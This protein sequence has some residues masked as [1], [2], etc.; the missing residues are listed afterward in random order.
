VRVARQVRA[1]L[2]AGFRVDVVALRGQGEPARETIDGA[3]VLRLPI[4][5]RRGAGMLR[6]VLEYTGFVLL[7]SIVVAS[8]MPRRRYDVVQVHNPPDFL[9]AAALP[10]RLFGAGV[11]LDIHDLSPDMFVTRYGDRPA[12]G[13]LDRALR[14]VERVALSLSHIV[15]TVHEPYRRELV[16]RGADA[17]RT[18]VVMNSVDEELLPA[19]AQAEV[20]GFRI[21]YH[22]TVT[23]HYGVQLIVDA[24][25]IV[26]ASVPEARLEV[27]GSGDAAGGVE[28]A[29]RRH[30]L[31]DRVLVTPELPHLVVLERIQGASAGVVPNL[32]NRLNRFALSTKLFEYV[33]SG[34]PAVVAGLPTLR[35][36]FDESEVWF[37]APGDSQSLAQA[38]AA[39]AADPAEARRRAAAAR[40]R[41]KPYAWS[42]QRDLYVDALRRASER[43]T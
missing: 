24:L 19:G 37:F 15:L 9:V 3:S 13:L 8:R 36:H 20:D 29:A 14:L 35:E 25:A 34:I 28:A 21:V 33:A 26:V 41:A 10:P 31:A 2:R 16:D 27:Y 7:A 30:G 6:L 23:P 22:G 38:L 43:R 11:V 1:A 17:A 4:E 42:V 12:A 18:I 32:P 39:V 5:H 40:E